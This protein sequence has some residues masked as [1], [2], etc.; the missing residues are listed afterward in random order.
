[1]MGK[2]SVIVPLYNKEKYMEEA[3]KSLL[4]QTIKIDQITFPSHK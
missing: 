3:I 4:S 1:M 2:I